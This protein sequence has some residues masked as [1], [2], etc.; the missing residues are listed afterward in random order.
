MDPNRLLI[1]IVCL[2]SGL[3]FVQ[4]A[5]WAGLQ[6]TTALIPGFI[7]LTT[8]ITSLLRPD[9][10]GWIGGVLWGGLLLVP[11]LAFR[12]ISSLIGGGRY[13]QAYILARGVAG[14]YWLYGLSDLPRFLKALVEARRGDR[15]QAHQ[16]LDTLG[17]R[18]STLVMPLLL[19]LYRVTARWEECL[20][21]IRGTK[22]RS[23]LDRDPGL[24]LAYLRALGETGQLRDL[25]WAYRQV[26]P[27]RQEAADP[28]LLS[29]AQL[30]VLAFCGQVEEVIRLFE[31]PLSRSSELIRRFW[32]ATARQAAGERA[33]LG[34]EWKHL[35]Q[36]EESN[37]ESAVQRRLRVELAD[38]H[39]QLGPADWEQV[40]QIGLASRQLSLR[41]TEV[42]GAFVPYATYGLILLNLGVFG[43]EVIL[44]GSTNPE[45]LYLLGGLDPVQ[46]WAG[47]W[48]RTL[49]STLL[50]Y[51]L[52]HLVM[53][54]LGLLVLGQ[55]VERSLGILRY[56]GVYWGAGVG[57]MTVI[58]VLSVLG[59][60]ATDF[61][62]GASG[63]I[64]GMVGASAAILWRIWHRERSPQAL[65]QLRMILLI[66]V[67]QLI[68]DL[69]T[70]QISIV[71][72]TSGLILGFLIA[73][74]MVLSQAEPQVWGEQ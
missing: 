40:E 25:V 72:H 52:L 64:M 24:G 14:L 12:Q 39:R 22:L 15:A 34:R 28:Q 63:S 53:N 29:L 50:H 74:I 59:W 18:T 67:L 7:L 17:E 27:G 13:G 3:N 55:M 26:I 62:V 71:G 47:E 57:S 48:W 4:A 6:S 36:A 38:P 19:E 32:V 16:V 65:R 30:I 68:F 49:T 45:T 73:G 51:G 69:T 44:G 8:V 41:G 2:S 46:V 66:I 20:G 54:M 60:S 31:G 5:V 56:L 70:P 21:W 42:R 10:G 61:V 35:L 9:L 33:R 43:L 58:T 11:S 1:W 23:Q 37:L